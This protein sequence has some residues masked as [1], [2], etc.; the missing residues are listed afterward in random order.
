MVYQVSG[1]IRFVPW[2]GATWEAVRTVHCDRWKRDG[3]DG[4]RAMWLPEKLLEA[5]PGEPLPIEPGELQEAAD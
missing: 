3:M 1:T 2:S 5:D 4:F